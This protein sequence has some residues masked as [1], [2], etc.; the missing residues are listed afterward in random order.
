MGYSHYLDR[1]KDIPIGQWNDILLDMRKVIESAPEFSPAD[2]SEDNECEPLLI[3]Y[4]RHHDDPPQLDEHAIMFNGQGTLGH[5]DFF[6]A[7][8]MS[9]DPFWS[10][11]TNLK[12]YDYFVCAA[13]LLIHHYAPECQHIESDGH[14]N[15]WQSCLDSIRE[16]LSNQDIQLPPSIKD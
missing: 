8:K 12:P 11:K 9:K 14:V 16:I 2:L 3:Q 10:C 7:Q 15:R 4:R 13:L 1:Q 6:I 5:E